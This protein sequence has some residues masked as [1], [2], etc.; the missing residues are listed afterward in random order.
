MLKIST[1]K[2]TFVLAGTLLM[3]A[4]ATGYHGEAAAQ[5]AAALGV[6]DA[7]DQARRLLQP[8][9]GAASIGATMSP[10]VSIT[11]SAVTDAQ[12]SARSLLAHS[13]SHTEGG[14]QVEGATFSLVRA[15]AHALAER[16]LASPA[17]H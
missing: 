15:D 10:T 11:R 4:L 9:Y 3:A 13:G 2:P 8:P 1:T 6:G 14:V 7:H 12:E 16:L 17:A 5:S